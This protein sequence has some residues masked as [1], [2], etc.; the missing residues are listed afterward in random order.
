MSS[1]LSISVSHVCTVNRSS[2][3]RTP[4]AYMSF[5]FSEHLDSFRAVANRTLWLSGEHEPEVVGHGRVNFDLLIAG[6]VII[7]GFYVARIWRGKCNRSLRQ[8]NECSRSLIYVE[9][10]SAHLTAPERS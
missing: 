7:L 6:S 3:G 4:I 2:V 8:E 1:D 9:V 10:K 5:F